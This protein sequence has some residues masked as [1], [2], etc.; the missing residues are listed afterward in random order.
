MEYI[1]T[2]SHPRVAGNA[3]IQTN[4]LLGKKANL[5]GKVVDLEANSQEIN[6]EDAWTVIK[7]YFKQHGLVSQQISSFN[8]FINISLQDIITEN[9][10]IQIEIQPQYLVSKFIYKTHFLLD[11][12]MVDTDKLIVWEVKFGQ[13]SVNSS[14]RITEEDEKYGAVFPHEARMRNLTYATEL[15]V[16]IAL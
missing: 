11:K 2:S 16:D 1:N 14:P 13:A 9:G 10:E 12:P 8:R 6:Q 7:A 3:R 4:E 15:F 5:L